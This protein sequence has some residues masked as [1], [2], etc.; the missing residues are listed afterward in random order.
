V[1]EHTELETLRAVIENAPIGICL[2]DR[3]RRILLWNRGAERIT[4]YL[5]QELVGRRC[6]DDVLKDNN[7]GGQALI[8]A[9]SPLL[10]TIRDGRRLE[11][12]VY[13]HH[14]DGHQMAVQLWASPLRS[15]DG[16]ILG[17]V[18]CFEERAVETKTQDLAAYGCLD[19]TTELPNAGFTRFYLGEALAAFDEY[20]LP[21][22]VLRVKVREFAQIVSTRGKAAADKLL[23]M[24]GQTLKHTLSPDDVVGRWQEDEFLVIA[25]GRNPDALRQMSEE[26][27]AIAEDASIS[28]WGDQLSV[29][30]LVAVAAAQPKDTLASLL[31][32]SAPALDPCLSPPLA[33]SSAT[34][35]P[36]AK[37][38]KQCS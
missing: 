37:D 10:E 11:A 33:S 27:R 34:T 14:K 30:V 18:E 35:A 22:G 17:A 32:R 24:L 25:P 5:R 38:A 6:S 15:E 21:F 16:A 31:E 7:E 12:H 26:V 19:A 36:S 3:E 1:N 13:L 4:G 29:Q 8:G 28:W 9:H 20:H 23:H 2:V